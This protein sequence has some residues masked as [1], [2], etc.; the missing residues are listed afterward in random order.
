MKWNA[1]YGSDISGEYH[2][3]SGYYCEINRGKYSHNYYLEIQ[4]C[5]KYKFGEK[6]WRLFIKM[7]TPAHIFDYLVDMKFKYLKDAKEY[8]KRYISVYDTSLD[9]WDLIEHYKS[10]HCC[11]VFDE[12]LNYIGE[13]Y[14]G[15]SYVTTPEER[16]KY[17]YFN[18]APV[19][20][21]G[22]QYSLHL[23]KDK[24]CLNKL[25]CYPCVRG[26]ESDSSDPLID[27][28]FEKTC[29]LP[30]KYYD[31]FRKLKE[32]LCVQK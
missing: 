1:F 10:E 13:E 19:E 32:A 17:D 5:D 12:D 3:T 29:E 27:A 14:L 16:E 8:A 4:P 20:Y 26:I 22:K 11:P 31:R 6:G 25:K 15:M 30:S 18:F 21:K 2:R 7:G 28:L 24:L 9:A 23:Y